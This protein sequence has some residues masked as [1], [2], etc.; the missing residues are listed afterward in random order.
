MRANLEGPEIWRVFVKPLS[1]Q[2]SALLKKGL[3]VVLGSIWGYRKW[4][5]G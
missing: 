3:N 4:S 1:C 5:C 2:K